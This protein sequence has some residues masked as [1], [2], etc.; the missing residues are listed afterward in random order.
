MSSR[1]FASARTGVF[2]LIARPAARPASRIRR[3]VGSIG[4]SIS[5]WNVIESQPA[6]M[7]S[8]DVATGLADHQV[9]VERQLG[10]RSEVP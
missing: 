5:T 8:L 4:S 3:S 6:S 10:P 9:G 2:G 1:Y 7:N